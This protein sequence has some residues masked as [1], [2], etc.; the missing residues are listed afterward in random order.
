MTVLRSF[1]RAC[2]ASDVANGGLRPGT[3]IWVGPLREVSSEAKL[4]QG[5]H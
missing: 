3:K 1:Q 5:W 2:A 4:S